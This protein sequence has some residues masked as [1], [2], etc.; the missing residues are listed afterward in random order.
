MGPG[1]CYIRLGH[2][3]KAIHDVP[4]IN[5]NRSVVIVYSEK[6]SIRQRIYMSDFP[7]SAQLLASFPEHIVG[8]QRKTANLVQNYVQRANLEWGR[9]GQ[10]RGM[11]NSAKKGAGHYC[12]KTFQ[13]AQ[14]EKLSTR[15]YYQIIVSRL[16]MFS[17]FSQ[18]PLKTASALEQ[19]ISSW[20]SECLSVYPCA[21]TNMGHP[22]SSRRL[23]HSAFVY[24]TLLHN[25]A[26]WGR[27]LGFEIS[28]INDE[29]ICMWLP[30]TSG[31]A[32]PWCYVF[33]V[34]GPS[35]LSPGC[36]YDYGYNWLCVFQNKAG[37][38]NL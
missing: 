23:P 12:R 36:H 2:V 7:E 11:C 29:F 10:G 35:S 19:E 24:L 8:S 3:Y 20:S 33:Q 1:C 17:L 18:R 21:L 13:I 6:N 26:S 9:G 28:A 15:A 4:M 32:E 31:N 16:R 25:L 14:E 27:A 30:S 22:Q 37:S 38:G 34:S 5:S